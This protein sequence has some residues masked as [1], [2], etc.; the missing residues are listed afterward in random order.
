[1]IENNLPT[2]TLMTPFTISL[3][4]GSTSEQII[5]ETTTIDTTIGDNHQEQL[6]CHITKA[7]TQ[8]II[9]GLDW[10]KKHNPHIN[11][12]SLG[13]NFNSEY[14]KNNCLN[15]GQNNNELGIKLLTNNAIVPTRGSEGA[16]G[17]DLYSA[18]D[19]VIME[20][21]QGRIAT[22]IAIQLPKGTCHE[23]FRR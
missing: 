6:T 23:S 21:S 20:N 8:P 19:L 12:D 14:C 16:I 11:F 17:L 22:D 18:V 15:I 3:A 4:D 5:E 13:I 10:M 7:L 2:K 1:V 9:L